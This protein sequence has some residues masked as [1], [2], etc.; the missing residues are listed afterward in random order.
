MVIGQIYHGSQAERLFYVAKGVRT[1]HVR[2]AVF[3]GTC[4]GLSALPVWA[5]LLLML[6]LLVFVYAPVPV[7]A[8]TRA[9]PSGE[10]S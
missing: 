9:G 8:L 10:E 5:G 2:Y 3:L 4:V 6:A 7:P 1:V